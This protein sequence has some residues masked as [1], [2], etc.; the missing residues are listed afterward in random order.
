MGKDLY[1]DLRP[2]FRGKGVIVKVSGAVEAPGYF[3]GEMHG[4][5]PVGL[6]FGHGD[7]RCGKGDPEGFRILVVIKEPV[8]IHFS[9]LPVQ[10]AGLCLAR[11]L[12]FDANLFAG[13]V[14]PKQGNRALF[15]GQQGGRDRRTNG[16]P[17]TDLQAVDVFAAS[18]ESEVV[19]GCEVVTIC[20]NGMVNN[21]VPIG[22]VPG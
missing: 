11:C 6:F 9:G 20:R 21:R 10:A 16:W 2:F 4:L 12:N 5:N 15:P 14:G 7:C 1:E 18:R 22:R 17:G 19:H 8:V 13:Q 3:P